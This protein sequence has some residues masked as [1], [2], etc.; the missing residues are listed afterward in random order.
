[1]FTLTGDLST[2]R[3]LQTATLLKDGTVLVAGGPGLDRTFLAGAELLNLAAGTFSPAGSR[4]TARESKLL[5]LVEFEGAGRRR[6]GK[7]IQRASC[8]KIWGSAIRARAHASV[9]PPLD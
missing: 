5:P 6:E 4:H 8:A 2:P 1:M 7:P 9:N 3:T